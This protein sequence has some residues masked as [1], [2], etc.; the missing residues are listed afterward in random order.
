MALSGNS[1]YNG[2]LGASIKEEWIFELRNNTYSS[3]SA[4]TE[5]IRL[6][7]AE[8][9]SSS[10]IYHSFITNIPS[11]RESIDLSKSTA[12][13]GNISLTCVNGALANHSNAT[14]AAEIYGGT[15]RYINHDVIVHSRVGGYTEQIFKAVYN[16]IEN[17]SILQHQ[18]KIGNF[19][20]VFYGTGTPETSTVSSPDFVDAARVFPVQVDSLNN[21]VFNCLAH[22]AVDDGRLHYPIKDMYDSTSFPIFVPLDDVQNDS[23]DDYEGATNDTNKNVL[24]T[25]LDLERS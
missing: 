19:F 23:H 15:R 22:K 18:S 3:G 12:S 14:L 24:F 25:D 6:G 1:D 21:D 13:V 20:P 9:G 16:P 8:V 7:T 17:I 5:Y 11:I 10:T 4:A 2:A